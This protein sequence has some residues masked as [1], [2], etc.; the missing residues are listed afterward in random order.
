[1]ALRQLRHAHRGAAV[2]LRHG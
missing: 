1:M 2:C